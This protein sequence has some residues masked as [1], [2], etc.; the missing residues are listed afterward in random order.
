MVVLDDDGTMLD[1]RPPEPP[2]EEEIPAWQLAR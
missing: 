1:A 2:I